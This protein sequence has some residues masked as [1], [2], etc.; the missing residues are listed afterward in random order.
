MSD[1]D[2]DIEY[3]LASQLYSELVS[4]CNSKNVPV[5]DVGE[6]PRSWELARILVK[7]KEGNL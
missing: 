2:W 4:I 5:P 1:A 7:Y 3:S 6:Y